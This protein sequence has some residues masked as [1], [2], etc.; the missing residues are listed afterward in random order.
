LIAAIAPTVD[1]EA[2]ADSL[3]IVGD[4]HQRIYARKASMSKCA[5]NVRGRSRKLKVCYRTS[6]EIRRWAVAIMQG[7]TVDDLDEV[8]AACSTALSHRLR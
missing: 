1:G 2:S 4:A 3:F 6:D 7:V 8:T 5:I